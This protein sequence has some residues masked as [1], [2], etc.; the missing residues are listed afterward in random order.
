MWKA[1]SNLGIVIFIKVTEPIISIT[2]S[3]RK[4]RLTQYQSFN[5]AFKFLSMFIFSFNLM[6]ILTN[7]KCIKKI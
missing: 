1:D 5:N 4:S 2:T 7:V 6:E 3:K